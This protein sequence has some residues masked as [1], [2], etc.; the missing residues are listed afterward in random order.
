MKIGRVELF[1]YG[2]T[3]ASGFL[4]KWSWWDESEGGLSFKIGPL[5]I[6]ITTRR[7]Q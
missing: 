5:G 3:V 7:G 2:G 4:G 1:R 6:A